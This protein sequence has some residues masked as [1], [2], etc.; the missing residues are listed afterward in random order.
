MYYYPVSAVLTE[1]LILSVVEQQ[2]SYGYE[3]SQTVKMVASIKES[4]C[5]PSCGSWR[6]VVILQRIPKSSRA[7]SESIIPSQ[8]TDGSS[9][10]I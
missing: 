8:K 1:C 3:I 2:D 5:I 6:Q 9:W 10:N 4:T 7:G